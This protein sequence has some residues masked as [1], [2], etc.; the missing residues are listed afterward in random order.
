LAEDFKGRRSRII[1][2]AVSLQDIDNFEVKDI[3]IPPT[4]EITDTV[5]GPNG[6]ITVTG[7]G[8]R[9]S[10][11][12]I[13]IDDVLR[14]DQEVKADSSGAYAFV[15]SAAGLSPGIHYLQV[16]YRLA[17]SAIASPFSAP[18][19]FRV[20]LPASIQADFNSDNKIDVADFSIF[21]SQWESSDE[22]LRLKDDFNSDNKIDVADFSIF[23]QSF[24]NL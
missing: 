23:L 7:Y 24:N 10:A 14:L 21:L 11:I 4:A 15:E 3:I 12:E 2:F 16:R 20:S 8:G 9:Y 22:A 18:L 5:V 19:A 17:S 1:S 13:T 6:K